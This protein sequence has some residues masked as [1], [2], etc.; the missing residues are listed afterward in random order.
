MS[1]PSTPV[2]S[3]RTHKCSLGE[4]A[5]PEIPFD[6]NM[7]NIRYPPALVYYLYG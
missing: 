3:Q 6:G 1:S 4:N 7:E 2:V 5:S